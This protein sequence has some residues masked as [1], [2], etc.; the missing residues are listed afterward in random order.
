MDLPVMKNFSESQ[1]VTKVDNFRKGEKNLFWFLKLGALSAL[2]YAIW[3]YALPPILLAVGQT[4]GVIASG[5]LVGFTIMMLPVIFK[6]LRFLTRKMH[7]S[8]IKFRPFDQLALTRE[9]MIANQTTFRVAKQNLIGLMRDMELE[10]TKSK[11]DAEKGNRDILKAKGRADVI[12]EQ[13][14]KMV[15][16]SGT[17][18]KGEDAYVELASE[19]QKT[20]ATANQLINKTKQANDFTQKFGTRANILKKVNQKLVMVETAMDIKISDFDAT[21]EMLK[22]DYAFGQKANAATSAA[23]SVLGFSSDWE[24]DLALE[25]ITN[26]ITA[27]IAN[28]AGNLKDIETLT[29]N[30][31]L[32]SDDLFSSLNAIADK[33]NIGE[34]EPV[35]NKQYSNPE[36]KLTTSD[37]QKSGGFGDLF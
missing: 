23:K 35:D 12:K 21:V 25:T 13:M 11:A 37:K 16:D 22:K 20:L 18:A 15:T 19:L 5:V 4:A 10:A 3:K 32:N 31:D 30:Y 1:L 14:E 33:I 24:R 2:G 6:G 27:D 8:V 7:E 17:A 9:K 36:Y 34:A 29:S 28:T 26:T